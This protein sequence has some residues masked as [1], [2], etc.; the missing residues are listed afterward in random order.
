[1]KNKY[2]ITAT[3][4]DEET[5]DI[6]SQN[7]TYKEWKKDLKYMKS[8]GIDTIVF[9]RGGLLN[10]CL[11][12]SKLLPTQ[13]KE[14][15][16]FL[17]FMLEES[18]KLG[19][20]VFIGLYLKTNN[21]GNGNYQE[22]IDLNKIFVKEV[23]ERYSKYENFVG[24]YF[25]TEVCCNELNIIPLLRGLVDLC[26]KESE[27]K[28]LYVSPLFKTRYNVGPERALSY[29]DTYKEWKEILKETGNEIDCIS[30]QDG[31]SPLDEYE[32]Y[33]KATKKACDEY[34]IEYWANV[35]TFERDLRKMYYP[36]PFELL[37]KKLEIASKYA[38]KIN[39]FEFSHFLSPQSMYPTAR[40]LFKRY[41]KYYKNLK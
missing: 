17:G 22:M 7:W 2:P 21:W 12:P 29:E 28:L 13:R 37:R 8:V 30:F 19:I 9:I 3:F 5:V 26:K 6:P 25:P 31:T 34:G 23:L 33:L 10:R 16:D 14:N 4:I 39:T 11:Y 36:A 41:K 15:E 20:K 24:W 27:D 32:E 38:V 18:R 1:M 35:E 40:N